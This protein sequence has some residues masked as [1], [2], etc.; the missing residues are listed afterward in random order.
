M[1]FYSDP[2]VDAL[3]RLVDDENAKFFYVDE[4]NSTHYGQYIP[5]PGELLTM[6]M[7]FA[8]AF[9]VMVKTRVGVMYLAC[10]NQAQRR[11]KARGT[12]N[13]NTCTCILV[14]ILPMFLLLFTAC[15]LRE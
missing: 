10:I 14:S 7:T 5:I 15:I 3:T 4:K 2:M 6:A 8:V 1:T 9:Y 12:V 11:V 13:T